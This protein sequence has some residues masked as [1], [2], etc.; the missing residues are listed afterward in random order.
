MAKI[1]NNAQLSFNQV[2]MEELS[3][4]EMKWV[5]GGAFLAPAPQFQMPQFQMPEFQMPEFQIPEF[6]MPQF[7]VPEFKMPEF[8]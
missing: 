3:D 5:T 8:N 1:K 7:Q 6:K 2:E 4:A